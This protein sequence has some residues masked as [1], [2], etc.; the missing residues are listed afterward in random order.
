MIRLNPGP[1]PSVLWISGGLTHEIA[2]ILDVLPTVASLAGAQLPKVILDGV[3]MT[4]LLINQGRVGA[5]RAQDELSS[6]ICFSV[7]Q[8]LSFSPFEEQKGDDDVL[9]HRSH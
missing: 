3:D 2:S 5:S 8:V 6:T 1:S 7:F 9:P 4:E